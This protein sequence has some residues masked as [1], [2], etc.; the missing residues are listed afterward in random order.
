MKKYFV[1]IVLVILFLTQGIVSEPV[2]TDVIDITY[3][4]YY[5]GMLESAGDI[6]TLAFSGTADDSIILRFNPAYPVDGVLELFY[7]GTPL[8][9]DHA[10]AGGLAEL[11]DYVLPYTGEY[12]FYIRDEQGVET[13]VYWLTLQC[14]Q[15]VNDKAVAIAYDI[16]VYDTLQTVGDIDGYTF[17]G[18]A[19][20]SII[21]RFNPAHPI[22]GALELFYE[23]SL[24]DEGHASSGGLGNPVSDN[25]DFSPW[26][27]IDF[28]VCDFTVG[29]CVGY[30]GNADCSGD[31]EP[32]IADITRLIDHL[33]LSHKAL[34]CL[35]EADADASGKPGLEPDISDITR[36]IDYLYLSHT[37]LANCP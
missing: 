3:D 18:T 23:S 33:Y 11:F 10:V 7:D 17:E 30:T 1:L 28:T 34:C 32:D 27:N 14:R 4:Y 22:D 31:E 12:V 26:C 5:T 8:A 19:G 37:P 21:L 35:E 13:S 16:Y 20:D 2:V 9:E 15:D 6:D 36:L 29:C 25:V 24:V